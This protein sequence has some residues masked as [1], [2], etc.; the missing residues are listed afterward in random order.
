MDHASGSNRVDKFERDIRLLREAIEA[1]PERLRRQLYLAQS[2]RG[3]GQMAKAA[4]IYAKRAQ[5]GGGMYARLRLARW[6]QNTEGRGWLS[7]AS[8]RS[9]PRRPERPKRIVKII[10]LGPCGTGRGG[11]GGILQ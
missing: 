4:E 5:M 1:D 9:C 11:P 6:P 3:A 7:A 8:R 2:Y 10:A